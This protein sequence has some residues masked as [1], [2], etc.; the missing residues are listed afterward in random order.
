[1]ADISV[2]AAAETYDVFPQ[3]EVLL[4]A[5]LVFSTIG[6]TAATITLPRT[7]TS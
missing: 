2:L 3:V 1:V 4:R 7:V 6:P 5:R